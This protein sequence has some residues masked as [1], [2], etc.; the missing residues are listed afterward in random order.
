[1]SKSQV[2]FRLPDALIAALKDKAETEGK[3]T[4]EI[5]VSILETGLGL[6]SPSSSDM[7]IA[8]IEERIAS[9]VEA[10][11]EQVTQLE[12]RIDLR[13]QAAIQKEVDTMLGE[14]IA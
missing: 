11:R 6:S 12:Q 10:V 1:M 5:A 7:R 8:S 9:Q 13:I 3:T 14:S 4:T 2:N